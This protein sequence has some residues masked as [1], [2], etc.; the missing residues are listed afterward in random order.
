MAMA[1]VIYNQDQPSNKWSNIEI[2][3]YNYGVTLN[4]QQRKDRKKLI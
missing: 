2:K 3:A 4:S 1:N